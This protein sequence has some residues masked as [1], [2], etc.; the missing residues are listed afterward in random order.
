MS[1]DDDNER[2]EAEQNIVEEETLLKM[3]LSIDAV[4][5]QIIQE[6][7]TEDNTSN[8]DNVVSEEKIA[9]QN[10]L[11][12]LKTFPFAV[13]LPV[14]PLSL[15]FHDNDN[16]NIKEEGEGETKNLET[17]AGVSLLFLRKKT[18]EKG[19]IDGGIKFDISLVEKNVEEEESYIGGKHQQKMQYIIQLSAVRNSRGQ[20]IPKI[21]SEKAIITSI[22]KS[23]NEKANLELGLNID[24]VYHKWM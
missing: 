9:F 23:I 2:Q 4:S 24:S 1:F 11:G 15:E 21:F 17:A 5:I 13:I 12:F 14:Q 7:R 8:D 20:S 3:N 16:N 22:V 18:Q 19:S 6:Q 10:M